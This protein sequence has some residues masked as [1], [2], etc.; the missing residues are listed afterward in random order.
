MTR[1]NQHYYAQVART[2]KDV[3][4]LIETLKSRRMP[5]T[6]IAKEV[7]G[8]VQRRGLTLADLERQE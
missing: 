6:E 3:R 8:L 1:E 5:K 7:L 4:Y 2:N